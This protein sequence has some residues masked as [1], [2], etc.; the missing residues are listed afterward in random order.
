MISYQFNNYSSSSS[1]FLRG[2]IINHRR[3]NPTMP[4]NI[5]CMYC[6]MNPMPFSLDAYVVN[7]EFT[8][9]LAAYSAN[10]MAEN[11]TTDTDVI[12]M[13]SVLKQN[14]FIKV[15]LTSIGYAVN[16]RRFTPIFV[17]PLTTHHNR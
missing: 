15:L 3:D 4:N 6:S 7:I 8:A 5:Y 9:V 10:D 12:S 11:C 1:T 14:A 16:S 17:Q 13:R 2:H